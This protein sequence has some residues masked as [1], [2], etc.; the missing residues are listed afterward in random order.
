MLVLSAHLADT[1]TE[2]PEGETPPAGELIQKNVLPD[3]SG[4]HWA[5][6]STT[7]A[8]WRSSNPLGRLQ[9]QDP[10][11]SIV[12]MDHDMLVRLQRDY[13]LITAAYKRALAQNPALEQAKNW[14]VEELLHEME[15]TLGVA[16]ETESSSDEYDDDVASQSSSPTLSATAVPEDASGLIRVPSPE[17]EALDFERETSEVER[18]E[19]DDGTLTR[20]R[21]LADV[22]AD[23]DSDHESLYSASP[24]RRALQSLPQTPLVEPRS[25]PEVMDDNDVLADTRGGLN[26]QPSPDDALGD[27]PGAE[28]TP[29]DAFEVHHDALMDLDD[30]ASDDSNGASWAAMLAELS[31]EPTPP[32]RRVRRALRSLQ[33]LDEHIAQSNALFTSR[34]APAAQHYFPVASDVDSLLAR[35]DVCQAN[36]DA[37]RARPGQRSAVVAP[38]DAPVEDV[39]PAPR[40][41]LFAPEALSVASERVRSPLLSP[42]PP[43]SA[44]R[45]IPVG[46]EFMGSPMMISSDPRYCAALWQECYERA[47]RVRP[48]LPFLEYHESD[49]E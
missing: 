36:F 41:V 23:H 2:A 45:R 30:A 39:R 34:S 17:L 29:Q 14:S 49:S 32:H 22:D 37:L 43:L 3:G 25:L 6:R 15:V 40:H 5:T 31:D 8:G 21:N 47:H 10:L 42:S 12:W 19:D 9:H 20:P 4:H 1:V 13:A 46:D 35:L 38:A 18:E 11:H 7:I 26:V 24:P 44:R 28:L 33:T 16:E 48:G 27:L